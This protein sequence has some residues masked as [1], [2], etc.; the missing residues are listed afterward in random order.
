VAL[1][2][3][4]VSVDIAAP[5]DV[6]WRFLTTARGAWWPEMRFEAVVGSPLVETWMEEGRQ[7]SAVGTITR[8]D[9][10]QLLGFSWSEEGWEAPLEVSIRLVADG[11]ATAVTLNES[12][13]SQI[14][15]PAE[16][17]ADHEDGWRY[18]LTRLKR[19]A[20]GEAVDVDLG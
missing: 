18:H 7:A 10:Q 3:V 11:Q 6:V 8:C 4:T 20:E 14:Q 2:S 1:D 16:L 9:E 13:F 15:A 12:G 5:I 17:S 19:V